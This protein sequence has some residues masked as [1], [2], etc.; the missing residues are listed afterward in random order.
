MALPASGAISLS[1]VN[2]ELTLGATTT[3]S[4]NDTTVRTL[5]GV[6]SGAID[7]NTG[8]GKSNTKSVVKVIV[9][10]TNATALVAYNWNVST[11]WGAIAHSSQAVALNGAL[12]FDVSLAQDAVAACSNS[13]MYTWRYSIASGFTY[14]NSAT[15]ASI[16]GVV[17]FH[18]SGNFVFTGGNNSPGAYL[19]PFNTTS[20]AGTA[21]TI[22]AQT[23]SSKSGVG[24]S[25]NGQI[26]VVGSSSPSVGA[27]TFNGTTLAAGTSLGSR[28]ESGFTWSDDGLFMIGSSSNVAFS[29]RFCAYPYDP[30]TDTFN[31]AGRILNTI[32]GAANGSGTLFSRNRQFIISGVTSYTFNGTA[33]GTAATATAPGA[34]AGAVSSAKL[35]PDGKTYFATFAVTP[36][37]CA[38]PFDETTGQFGAKYADPATIPTGAS[39]LGL[40]TA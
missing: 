24:W 18:P 19:Y 30:A 31:V 3:I 26:L 15:A 5:F 33:F 36:F 34:P 1:D 38:W 32:S 17:A 16:P 35:S 29:T 13:I 40:V 9:V 25:P 10:S 11:G 14:L 4:L 2:T 39:K 23:T 7:M 20:G 21:L 6:A 12:G 28:P 22:P 8:H 37:I 27:Y